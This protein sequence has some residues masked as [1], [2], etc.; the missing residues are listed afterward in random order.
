MAIVVYTP[1]V[2]TP[3]T[4]PTRVFELTIWLAASSTVRPYSAK[5]PTQCARIMP[6]KGSIPPM[7]VLDARLSNG[8]LRCRQSGRFSL[9]TARAVA[10][11]C[12]PAPWAL[13]HA[14]ALLVLTQASGHGE[15]GSGM[16]TTHRPQVRLGLC[17]AVVVGEVDLLK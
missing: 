5:R 12:L 6:G 14:K 10:N 3:L 2:L 17:V 1:P 9:A 4:S 11:T 8:S 16:R 13:A 7:K 15:V